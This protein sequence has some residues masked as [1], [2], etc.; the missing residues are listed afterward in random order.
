MRPSPKRADQVE[1]E[2]VEARA[3]GL[4]GGASVAEEHLP[5][6]AKGGAER[7]ADAEPLTHRRPVVV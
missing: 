3:K 1:I 6:V 2:A 4:G 7:G 5:V